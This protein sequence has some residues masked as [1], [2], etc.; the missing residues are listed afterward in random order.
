[1]D[2]KSIVRAAFPGYR[3]RKIRVVPHITDAVSTLSYWDGGSRSTFV[4]VNLETG[5]ASPIAGINP[6]NPPANWREP[7]VIQ[8]GTVIVE[9]SIF[10]GKDTGCRIH[11]RNEEVICG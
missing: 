1:M 8:I 11:I 2:A 4:T 10:C 3:G 5:A 9:H 6:L 7:T